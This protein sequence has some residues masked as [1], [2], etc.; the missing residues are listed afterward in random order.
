MILAIETSTL[1]ASVAVVRGD[2]VLGARESDVRSHSEQ[3]IGL[4]DGVLADAHSPALRE[5]TSGAWTRGVER[6]GIFGVPSFVFAGRLYWGQDRM[7]FLRSAVE[8][9]AS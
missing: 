9:K 5:E 7:H 4:I 6:D 8:R 2:E 3:L 1:R